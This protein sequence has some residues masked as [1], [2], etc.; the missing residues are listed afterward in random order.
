M[1][2]LKD[3]L[4]IFIP[5]PNIMTLTKVNYATI[6]LMNLLVLRSLLVISRFNITF[7]M[8]PYL[9]NKLPTIQIGY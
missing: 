1:S 8:F 6:I 2:K 4:T 7:I 5:S 9:E 3:Y